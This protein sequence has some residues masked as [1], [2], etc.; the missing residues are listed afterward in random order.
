MDAKLMEAYCF[1]R[2]R[3]SQRRTPA[4]SCR[5]RWPGM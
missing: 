2:V 5:I 1:L 3:G 4:G